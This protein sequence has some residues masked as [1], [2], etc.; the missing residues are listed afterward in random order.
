MNI[1]VRYFS[2]SGNTKKLAEAIAQAAGTRATALSEP[3]AE[4]VHLLFIGSSVYGFDLDDTVKDYIGRLSPVDVKAVALFGTSA[5]VK[6][7]NQAM[8]KL[9][10]EVHITVLKESFYCRGS[11]SFL[12][13][14][15]PNQGDL[16]MAAA[17][18]RTAMDEARRIAAT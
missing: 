17:F 2:R 3:L 12:H 4:P 6:S 11:F 14:G 7:G 16:Q 1:Q 15:R 8:A 9:L 18:A 5:L 10:R 13:R